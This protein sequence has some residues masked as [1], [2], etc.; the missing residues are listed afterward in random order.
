MKISI[1]SIKD[2]NISDIIEKNLD[3]G[4][5]IYSDGKEYYIDVLTDPPVYI[6][7]D[8]SY[9]H[10]PSGMYKIKNNM[11]YTVDDVQSWINL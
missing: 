10:I 6:A 3:N 4:Y 1:G 5:S 9:M 7:P 11:V 2:K 8:V